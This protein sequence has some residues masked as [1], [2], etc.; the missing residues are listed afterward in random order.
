MKIKVHNSL[1]KFSN[2]YLNE[3]LFNGMILTC[4]SSDSNLKFTHE[5]DDDYYFLYFSPEMKEFKEGSGFG[6][7]EKTSNYFWWKDS[8]WEWQEMGE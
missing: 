7:R 4:L 1:G 3:F 8:C 6:K 5:I 2:Q